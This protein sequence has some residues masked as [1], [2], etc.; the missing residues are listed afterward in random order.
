MYLFISYLFLI[1][2]VADRLAASLRSGSSN[3]TTSTH[4]GTAKATSLSAL[5]RLQQQQQHSSTTQSQQSH[6][7]DYIPYH[8]FSHHFA[9][10]SAVSF[11]HYDRDLVA[12]GSLDGSLSICRALN[13]PGVVHLL[14]Q[15]AEDSES[16]SS[17]SSSS[18]GN[19]N[20]N[21]GGAANKLPPGQ[22]PAT[23]SSPHAILDLDWSM[24]NEHV[25]SCSKDGTAKIWD[26]ISGS[27]V[28][29][30]GSL[31]GSPI[32]AGRF[33]PV[34]N[35]MIVLGNAKS[36]I[37][38]Y[39]MSTGKV[40]KGSQTSVGGAVKCLEIHPQGSLLWV[41]D[42]HGQVTTFAIDIAT[43]KLTRLSKTAVATLES[44]PVTSIRFKSSGGNSGS[45][46]G[47]NSGGSNVTSSPSSSSSEPPSMLLVNCRGQ[48]AVYVFGVGSSTKGG[49]RLLRTFPIANKKLDLHSCWNPLLIQPGTSGG[50]YD[51]VSK[52]L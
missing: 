12:I 27:N 43:G 23:Y 2:S 51:I 24:A 4:S 31:G 19:G 11:A 47:G 13:D 16:S 40:F 32:T 21:G 8:S 36:H 45:G 15:K 3:T 26:L 6:G 34:N 17:S 38:M 42:A 46:S 50:P 28:R 9:G 30:L 37:E 5:S 48:D 1:V 7:Y 41:G 18:S 25:L 52:W 14:F 29:V 44:R 22:T 20:G 35:N 10:I 39:N 33:H 49:L